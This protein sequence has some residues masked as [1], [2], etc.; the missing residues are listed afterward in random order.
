MTEAEKY[1][2]EWLV[3]KLRRISYQ[4]PARKAALKK[5][6]VSR[7]KYRCK[8]C[9]EEGRDVLYGPK[10]IQVDH[11]DPVISVDTGF[12]DWNTYVKRLFCLEDNFQILCKDCHKIKTFFENE[13]RRDTKM[14]QRRNDEI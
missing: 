9:E 8:A 6:R 1:I 2:K 14:Q 13:L 12:I 11:T 10:D 5:A 7:G 4:W 3:N